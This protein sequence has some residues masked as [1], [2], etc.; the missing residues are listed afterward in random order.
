MYIMLDGG[1]FY[2]KNWTRKGDLVSA[3]DCR[4][5]QDDRACPRW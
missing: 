3:G 2:E 4:N 5:E 1:K